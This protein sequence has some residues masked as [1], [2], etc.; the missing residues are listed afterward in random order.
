MPQPAEL[1]IQLE[2]PC[3]EEADEGADRYGVDRRHVIPFEAEREWRRLMEIVLDE[4]AGLVPV[5]GGVQD[6]STRKVVDKVVRLRE[7]GYKYCAATANASPQTAA[8][9][10]ATSCAA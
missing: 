3:G 8:L 2:R 6:T 5:L 9:A 7:L 1:P 4:T 10:V